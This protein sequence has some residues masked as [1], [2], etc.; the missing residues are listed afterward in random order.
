VTFP[1]WLIQIAAIG[2]KTKNMWMDELAMESFSLT[3][4]KA[5]PGFNLRRN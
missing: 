4:I 2:K 3:R 1:F 5:S